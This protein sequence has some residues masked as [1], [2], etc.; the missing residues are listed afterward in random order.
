MGG[1]RMQIVPELAYIHR[2]HEGSWYK[3]NRSLCNK[4]TE[5]IKE[6]LKTA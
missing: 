2:A 3:K 1:N 5:T 4:N 6:K